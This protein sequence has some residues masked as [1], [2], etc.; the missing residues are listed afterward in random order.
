[1]PTVTRDQI[2]TVTDTTNIKLDISDMIDFL[3]PYDVPFIDMVGRDSLHSPA[4]QVKHEWLEDELTPR[5]GTLAN[6]YVADDDEFVFTAGEGKYVIPGDVILVGNETYRVTG[7][8]TDTIQVDHLSGTDAAH[9]AG[10][11]WRKVA[12]AAQEAG[13]ARNDMN[14]T[15]VVKKF[16]Y[17]QIIKDWVTLS[18]TMEVIRRYGYVSER[19][20]QESKKMKQLALDLEQFLMYGNRSYVEGPPRVSTAGGLKEYILDPGIT[21]SWSTVKD[22]SNAALTETMLIDVLEKIWEAGGEPNFIMVNGTN[23]RRM[24][25]W[26]IPRLRS[27]IGE[28]KAGASVM[29]YESDFAGD[30]DVILNRNIRGSD[31]IIGSSQHIGVGPLNGRQFTSRVLPTTMDG[32]WTE[33]MGEYTMEV[34]FPSVEFGWIYDTKTT[35]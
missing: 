17:T 15:H 33:I 18:G 35:Y 30:L 26:G 32:T 31:V 5:A 11:S 16:N 7:V 20:Y 6:A 14:K 2:N 12:H 23:K 28:R 25:D 27:S 24:T 3:S 34:H 1:M 9:A 21:N 8:A 29:V 10:A 4:E 22:A 13:V 19:A